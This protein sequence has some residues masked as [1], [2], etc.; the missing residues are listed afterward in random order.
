MT[1]SDDVLRN[2]VTLILRM[3]NQTVPDLD[4]RETIYAKVDAGF[5]DVSDL[6]EETWREGL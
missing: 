1:A 4:Q 3:V 5:P 2:T 6:I